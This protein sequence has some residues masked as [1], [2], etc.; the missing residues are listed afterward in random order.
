MVKNVLFVCTGNTCR[1]PMA[2][3]ML[4]DMLKKRGVKG[5]KVTSAGYYVNE[6]GTINDMARE[7]LRKNGVI[8][9]KFRSK[10]L[11]GDLVEKADI[12]LCM[13]KSHK[14]AL[15]E[16]EKVKTL[17]ELT[18]MPEIGDPYGG[19]EAAYDFCYS[20]LKDS[21]DK[22]VDMLWPLEEENSKN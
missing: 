5:V 2:E 10:Q 8:A 13:T 19:D 16:M 15:P 12:V 18:G 21:L 20:Q 11:D 9:R 4:K 14:S 3:F 1:S 6:Y 22:L 17:S 7:T